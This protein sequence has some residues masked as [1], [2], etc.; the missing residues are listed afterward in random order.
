MALISCTL[1]PEPVY[2]RGASLLPWI[3]IGNAK[4]VAAP[5]LSITRTV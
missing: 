2:R 5:A 1:S 4:S 3:V